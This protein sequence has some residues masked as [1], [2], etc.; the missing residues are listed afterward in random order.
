MVPQESAPEPARTAG[1]ADSHAAGTL[2][3]LRALR[4]ALRRRSPPS[5]PLGSTTSPRASRW[6]NHATVA[7]F[8][9]LSGNT[10]A[11]HD[12]IWCYG[13]SKFVDMSD[14]VVW[15]EEDKFDYSA[16]NTCN[17]YLKLT[18]CWTGH[19]FPDSNFRCDKSHPIPPAPGE[20]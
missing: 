1:R 15:G 17:E 5:S 11:Y 19:E 20:G 4:S 10:A 8:L 12:E 14:C 16:R 13:G 6:L 3:L 18:V 7:A 9:L 2:R